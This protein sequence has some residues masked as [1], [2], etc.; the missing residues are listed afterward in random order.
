MNATLEDVCVVNEQYDVCLDYLIPD[1]SV[2][3]N[4]NEKYVNGEWVAMPSYDTCKFTKYIKEINVNGNRTVVFPKIYVDRMK[5]ISD[6]ESTI[7][8]GRLGD[9]EEAYYGEVNAEID[10]VTMFGKGDVELL[11]YEYTSDVCEEFLLRSAPDF[12][13]CKNIRFHE[14]DYRWG[15]FCQWKSTELGDESGFIEKCYD[16]S[17]VCVGCED[18]QEGCEGLPLQDTPLPPPCASG[19]DGF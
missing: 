1:D 5:M 15:A 18:Y 3:Y 11:M 16:Q 9:S 7:A 13:V 2:L 14:L 17:R 19:W 4:L 6:S 8:F 10:R 12:Q